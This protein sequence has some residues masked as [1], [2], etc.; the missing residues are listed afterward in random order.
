MLLLDL[1]GD[2]CGLFGFTTARLAWTRW[3]LEI[4]GSE[5]TRVAAVNALD[6]RTLAP[7]CV[8]E[9]DRAWL[10]VGPDRGALLADWARR[11]GLEMDSRVPR[12]GAAEP[13]KIGNVFRPKI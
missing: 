7:G 1:G 2:L 3:E 9:S 13:T 12:Q 10:A 11:T 8:V 6:G 4:R 5:A